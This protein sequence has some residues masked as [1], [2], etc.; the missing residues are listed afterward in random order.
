MKQIL[1]YRLALVL[2]EKA[3]NSEKKTNKGYFYEIPDISVQQF[4][5]LCR[6]SGCYQLTRRRLLV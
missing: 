4:C 2:A 1:N 6:W 5:L 3:Q